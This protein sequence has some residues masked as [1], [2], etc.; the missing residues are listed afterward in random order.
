MTSPSARPSR[1]RQRSTRLLT[2]SLLILGAGVVVAAAA[3]TGSLVLTVLAGI[4]ATAL[5]AAAVR[6]TY[7]EVVDSRRDAGRDRAEQA[8]AYRRLAEERQAEQAIYVAETSG[9]ITRHQA[10]ISRLE[11]RLSEAAAELAQAR[12]DLDSERN[13]TR[14]LTAE[15]DR[16]SRSRD[17]AE[18][19]AALA[20]VRVAELEQEL[21]V[22]IS[23]WRAGQGAPTRKHA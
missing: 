7:A 17:D 2:A 6:I 1:R 12:R 10:T 14:R 5:G 18:E 9:R 21:D 22:V 23:E 11:E 16:L 20:I 4:A 19:R 8:Q 3:L 13:G 15:R